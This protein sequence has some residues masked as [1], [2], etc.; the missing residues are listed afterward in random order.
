MKQ[1][2]IAALAAAAALLLSLTG[3]FGAPASSGAASSMPPAGSGSQSPAPAGQGGEWGLA[4]DTTDLAGGAV[5]ATAF[6]ANRLTLL[7]VWATWCP[8]CV[9][10]LPELQQVSEAYADSG[11]Q[12]VG[13]LQDG[14]NE[15][16]ARDEEVIKAAGLLLEEAGADY[17]ILL[18]DAAL[19][20]TFINTMQYFP[21]TFFLDANGEVVETV[22]GSNDF[23]GWSEMIDE[24]LAKLG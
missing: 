20:E 6:A 10:E 17:L 22:V 15:A 21:T 3:C 9:A 24:T 12:V 1:K 4:L 19:N 2:R 18:P 7:N 23:A 8:P 5:D 13:V 11:V 16:G 14:V